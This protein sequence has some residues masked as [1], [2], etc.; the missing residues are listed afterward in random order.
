MIVRPNMPLL[1]RLRRV[2]EKAQ[3]H[4]VA[5]RIDP[6]E[7]RAA[8]HD[9][10]AMLAHIGPDPVPKELHSSPVA[11][12]LQHAGPAEFHEIAAGLG[13]D[14]RRDVVFA[15]GVEAVVLVGDILS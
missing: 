10:A 9:V 11:V 6:G 2:M 12:R 14:Q 5:G 7:T 1:G 8:D 13:L 15:L 4:R 3:R